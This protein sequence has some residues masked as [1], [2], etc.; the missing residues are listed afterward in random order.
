MRWRFIN[1]MLVGGLAG[2]L[3]AM[4][5]G[6]QMK[7]DPRRLLVGQTRRV[8]RRTGQI[9]SGVAREVQGFIRRQES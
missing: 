4:R 6:R 1:G 7:S 8:G 5:F 9:M 2:A 3:L